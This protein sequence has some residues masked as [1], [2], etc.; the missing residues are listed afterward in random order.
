MCVRVRVYDICI[1][2][3]KKMYLVVW[4]APSKTRC[5]GGLS[6]ML[7]HVVYQLVRRRRRHHRRHCRSYDI[8]AYNSRMGT[9]NGSFSVSFRTYAD[10][11]SIISIYSY[12]YIILVSLQR[13]SLLFKVNGKK[14]KLPPWEPHRRRRRR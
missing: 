6:Y 7:T 2:R 3:E 5:S 9:H 4:H 10:N 14:L 13:I 11:I 12:Y 8:Y 1:I